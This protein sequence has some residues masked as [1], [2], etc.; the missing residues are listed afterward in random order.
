M[1][2]ALSCYPLVAVLLLGAALAGCSERPT[3]GEHAHHSD[4][5][6]DSAVRFKAGRGLL[7]SADA[8]EALGV[9]TGELGEET[10]T[11]RYDVTATVFDPGP[12][13]RASAFVLPE[14]AENLTAEPAAGVRL[15]G[16]R[17]DVST[18]LGQVE[19]IL[20]LDRGAA[21][22]VPLPLILS[23]R[24]TSVAAAP[25][26]ALLR[27]AAGDFVYVVNG[28]HL[29]RTAV[30]TGIAD[31]EYIEIRN[32]LYPGDVIVTAGVEQ[33]W[34]TELRLTKG[35]GHSH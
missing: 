24:P 1:K 25:R 19:A 23:G 33:L 30:K 5:N 3:A 18:S 15:L 2:R 7:L 9:R 28:E 32:G 4:H 31:D 34:L 10:L 29:L 20:Q 27:T 8:A 14:A 35:G 26:S 16:I 11:P 22:G 17:R 21:V 6:G 12:P 13:A